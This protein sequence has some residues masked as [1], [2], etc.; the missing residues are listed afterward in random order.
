MPPVTAPPSSGDISQP[1]P[2]VFHQTSTRPPFFMPRPV[3]V[4]PNVQHLFQTSSFVPPN[5]QPPPF[6]PPTVYGPQ[7]LLHNFNHCKFNVF[8]QKH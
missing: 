3:F 2:H 6:M 8:W 7:T 1:A 5:I 4:Q